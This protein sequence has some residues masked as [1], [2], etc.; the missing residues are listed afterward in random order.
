M[1]IFQSKYGIG[2]LVYLK[3]DPDQ[4]QYIITE[5]FFS[6]GQAMY[7]ISRGADGAKVYEIELSGEPNESIRL[8]IVNH[9]R[10]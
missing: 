7:Y 1:N 4:F 3:T 8:G 5:V 9:E 6:P 10:N 2:D